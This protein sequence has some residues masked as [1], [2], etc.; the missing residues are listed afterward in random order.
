[1]SGALRGMASLILSF[2][3]LTEHLPHGGDEGQAPGLR[4]RCSLPQARPPPLCLRATMV[5][6]EQ[7]RSPGGIEPCVSP[8]RQNKLLRFNHICFYNT[9]EP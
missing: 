6:S 9:D 7:L 8:K 4:G 2:S 3:H 1:M 5:V